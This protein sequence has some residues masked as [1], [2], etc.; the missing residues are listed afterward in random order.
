[1]KFSNATSTVKRIPPMISRVIR[2]VIA[3]S[4]FAGIVI[5]QSSPDGWYTEGDFIP[6]R[7]I[8]VTITN[9]LDIDSEQCPVVIKRD[10]LPDRHIPVEW[11]TPVDPLLPPSPGPTP[12][13]LKEVGGGG[14]PFKDYKVAFE[15]IGL[16]VRDSYK[17]EYVN[18]KRFGGNH[19]MRVPVTPDHSFE[20]MILGGWSE[21]AVNTTEQ[22]FMEY[23][24]VEALKYNN[25]V[26]ITVGE[27]EQK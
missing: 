14:V 22:D 2:I 6:E 24:K 20:Y 17:P 26:T 7:R 3:L 5:A 10:R 25:P 23:V 18:T 8:E 19:V 21:G 16:V 13:Q 4:L 1:M 9:L 27:A 11:I 15:G 12:E